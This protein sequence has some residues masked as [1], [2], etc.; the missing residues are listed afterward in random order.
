MAEASKAQGFF[1]QLLQLGRSLLDLGRAVEGKPSLTEA[2]THMTPDE[3]STPLLLPAGEAHS[4]DAQLLTHT[5]TGL[6]RPA[7]V[8]AA[9]A[10][11]CAGDDGLRH[12]LHC[13]GSGHGLAA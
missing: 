10:Y 3:P 2:P 8:P 9:C 7:P 5:H 13:A 4:E 1:A 11:V 12:R 6:A